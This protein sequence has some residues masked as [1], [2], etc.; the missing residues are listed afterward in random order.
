MWYL[1]HPIEMLQI[2]DGGLGIP[3]AIIG[4]GLVLYLYA[5]KHK[6]NF[7]LWLDLVAP[8]LALAQAIGRWGNFF[9]QELYGKPSTLPWAITIDPAIPLAGISFD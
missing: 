3:G 2:W 6:Y 1:T 9:N 8:G 4:G 7:G 5:R